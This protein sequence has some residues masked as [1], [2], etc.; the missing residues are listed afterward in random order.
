MAGQSFAMKLFESNTPAV[1]PLRDV[2]LS[3][4]NFVPHA[5]NRTVDLKE[6]ADNAVHAIVAVTE[7]DAGAVY[8][9]QDSDQALRLFAWRGISEVFAR[10]VATLQKGDDTTIDAVLEGATKVPEDCTLAPRLFRASVVRAGFRSTVMCP[11]RAHGFVVG[12]LALGTYKG[13]VFEGDDIELIE[14][15]ANQIGNAMVPAQLG[16][17]LRARAARSRGAG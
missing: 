11:I 17:D 6:I 7:L 8:V 1:K 3:A 2:R 14:V 5:I 13:R 4:V 9:W 15:V 10:Q 16:P 12:M